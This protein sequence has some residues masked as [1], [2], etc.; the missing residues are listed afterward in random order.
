MSRLC[1]GWVLTV[2]GGGIA[3]GWGR[4]RLVG[5]MDYVILKKNMKK[6]H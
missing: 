3:C 5:H 1:P 2:G 6:F 4:G